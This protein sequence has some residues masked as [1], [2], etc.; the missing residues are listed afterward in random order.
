[1]IETPRDQFEIDWHRFVPVC[2]TAPGICGLVSSGLGS[3]LGPKSAIPGRI[4]KMCRGPSSSA[5]LMAHASD[6]G[7]GFLLIAESAV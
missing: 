6:A 3:D 1:M 7:D 4:L 2:G 5:E